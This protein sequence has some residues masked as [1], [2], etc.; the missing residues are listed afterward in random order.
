MHCSCTIKNETVVIT[1]IN[2]LTEKVQT[3]QINSITA[4]HTN[5]RNH[6]GKLPFYAGLLESH[7]FE[8]YS[9]AINLYIRLVQNCQ[10][11]H[12]RKQKFDI[13]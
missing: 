3:I 12:R 1:G 11:L 4:I 8:I 7:V 2:E 13:G 9:H 6:V 5:N 10:H